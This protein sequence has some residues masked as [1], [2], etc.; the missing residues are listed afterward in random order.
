MVVFHPGLCKI[1]AQFLKKGAK[2]F[3][4]G[5]LRTRKWTTS[6]GK[7]QFTTEVVLPAFEGQILLLDRPSDPPS[8]SS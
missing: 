7:D 8:S 3:V 5:E 6:D 4:E 2:A 1:A